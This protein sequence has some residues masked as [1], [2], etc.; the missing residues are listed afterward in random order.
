MIAQ[1]VSSATVL[2]FSL[3]EL[4]AKCL[5]PEHLTLTQVLDLI[6]S[7]FDI[8]G[9]IIPASPEIQVFSTHHGVLLFLRPIYAQSAQFVLSSC[10]S[11]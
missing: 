1:A 3:E 2:Y 10:I 5:H 4:H 9:Q 7:V 8:S 6:R 11:S